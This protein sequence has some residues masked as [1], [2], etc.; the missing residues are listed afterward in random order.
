MSK[1]WA[2]ADIETVR[3]MYLAGAS[4]AAITKAVG[5]GY[6]RRAISG[7]VH[8]L[9]LPK[10]ECWQTQKM[11]LVRMDKKREREAHNARKPP[12]RLVDAI[13][14]HEPFQFPNG[15][16][17]TMETVSDKT[18]RMPIGDPADA[19]FRYCGHP[20]KDGS[21]YCEPCHTRAHQPLK[22]GAT[23]SQQD[24]ALVAAN[25]RKSGL[26]RMFG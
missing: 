14:A 23:I 3:T 12:L 1:K 16:F 21:S 20:P 2:D 24:K 26:D 18:C 22:Q 11:T 15:E 6:T 19:D 7:V 17:V 9:K 13:I 4:Y 5:K 8:R 10:R 25:A